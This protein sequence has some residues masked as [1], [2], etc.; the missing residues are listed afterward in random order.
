MKLEVTPF[1][2][3]EDM[4]ANANSFKDKVKVTLFNGAQILDSDNLF[5]GG[6]VGNKL[7][8]IDLCKGDKIDETAL[9]ALL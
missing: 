1:W 2:P 8:A 4:Y 3:R 9:K 5:N 6:L 7:R